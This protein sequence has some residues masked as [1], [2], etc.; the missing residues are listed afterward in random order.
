MVIY[1]WPPRISLFRSAGNLPVVAN[2]SKNKL[3]LL[4]QVIRRIKVR[5]LAKSFLG[6]NVSQSGAQTG[7]MGEEV[8]VH[9]FGGNPL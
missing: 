8:E 2:K 9:P 6:L 5:S 3:L 7:Y 4:M 1:G